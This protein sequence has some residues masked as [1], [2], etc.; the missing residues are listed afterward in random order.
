M[1]LMSGT[2]IIKGEVVGYFIK[3]ILYNFGNQ[4]QY[5]LNIWFPEWIDSDSSY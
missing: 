3:N 4:A 2:D 1:L 5:S